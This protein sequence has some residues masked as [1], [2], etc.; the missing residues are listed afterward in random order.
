MEY[1]KSIK[2][3]K[4]KRVKIR[5]RKINIVAVRH[6]F[7]NSDFF[8][9]LAKA[10]SS[11]VNLSTLNLLNIVNDVKTVLTHSKVKQAAQLRNKFNM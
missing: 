5:I 7:F 4:L 11:Y 2:L 3:G 6:A 1:E 9:D 8:R 10:P